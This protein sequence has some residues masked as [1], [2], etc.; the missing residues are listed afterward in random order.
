MSNCV[1]V[2]GLRRSGTTALFRAL[3]RVSGFTCYDEPFNHGLFELPAEHRKNVRAEFVSTF[4]GNP[5][6]FWQFFAPIWPQ[7]EAID[8]LTD[9][10]RKFLNYLRPPNGTAVYESPRLLGSVASISSHFP[11]APIIHL[12]KS[13]AAF[14]TSHLVPSE[15]TRRRPDRPI[16]RRLTALHRKANYDFWQMQ[17][18]A[19]HSV[20]SAFLLRAYDTP[21]ERRWFLAQR[22]AV[23]LLIIW[24]FYYDL[25]E[26]GLVDHRGPTLRICYEDFMR[27]TPTVLQSLNNVLGITKPDLDLSSVR[28]GVRIVG[29]KRTWLGFAERAGFAQQHCQLLFKGFSYRV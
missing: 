15:W 18:M 12:Y 4:N 13:P 27:Q 5:D 11:D 3:R 6:R 21:D 1:F 19:E 16:R 26:T 17:T 29:S 20:E 2:L 14:A 10:R 23:K 25:V 7:Q 9:K 24:R 28:R 22:A 8:Q